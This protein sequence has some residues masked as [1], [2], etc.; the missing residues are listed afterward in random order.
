[1]PVKRR[2]RR[3]RRHRKD[4]QIRSAQ[5]RASR[6][7]QSESLCAPRYR[8]LVWCAVDLVGDVGVAAKQGHLPARHRRR[9][10]QRRAPGPSPDNRH[11]FKRHG[12]H[13]PRQS[14]Y[15][16]CRAASG[17]WR[18]FRTRHDARA[19]AVQHLPTRP[20][21][22]CRCKAESAA[23]PAVRPLRAATCPQPAPIALLA[24][25]PPATTSTGALSGNSRRNLSSAICDAL[26][27]DLGDR[28]L[29]PGADIG[30]VLSARA[31]RSPPPAAAPRS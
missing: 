2:P 11:L 21:R 15:R 28:G 10:C 13:R 23:R 31:A 1:M 12:A 29:E 26:R 22:H 17:P 30:D 5:L 6:V 24:A 3:L 27:D 14:P 16:R 7:I 8:V 18:R 25:T 19:P 4:H 20:W 9:L